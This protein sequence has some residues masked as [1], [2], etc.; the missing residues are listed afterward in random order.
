MKAKAKIPVRKFVCGPGRVT[1]EG[2][3]ASPSFCYRVKTGGTKQQKT[4]IELYSKVTGRKIGY[5]GQSPSKPFSSI[6]AGAREWTR[7]DMP[8]HQPREIPIAVAKKMQHFLRF[9]QDPDSEPKA[10]PQYRQTTEKA[11]TEITRA[12]RKK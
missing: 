12:A 2:K 8:A 3:K 1:A 4:V 11:W 10:T 5:I 6:R 7:K 9:A